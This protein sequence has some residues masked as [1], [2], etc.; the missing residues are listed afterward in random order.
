MAILILNHKF[1]KYDLCVEEK[2]TDYKVFINTG[3]D[4][5]N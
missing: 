1:C 5:D 3:V 2:R 4:F